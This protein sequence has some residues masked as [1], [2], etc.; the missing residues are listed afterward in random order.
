MIASIPR[1]MLIFV[2]T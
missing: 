1:G 2:W